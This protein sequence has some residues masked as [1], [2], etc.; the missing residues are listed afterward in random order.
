[1]GFWGL[2]WLA[3]VLGKLAFG[4]ALERGGGYMNS[5]GLSAVLIA[6][7]VYWDLSTRAAAEN[8]LCQDWRK[9]DLRL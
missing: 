7:R 9:G 4:F 8:L 1:V 2:G 5:L 6:G 3:V